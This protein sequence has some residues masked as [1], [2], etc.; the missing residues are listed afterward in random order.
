M[1]LKLADHLDVPLRERNSLLLSAGY[2]PR[3]G[4]M[5]PDDLAVEGVLG[6]LRRMLGAHEPY[7]GVVVDRRWN[8]VAANQAAMW[9]IGTTVVTWGEEPLNVFRVTLHPGGL[10]GY[11]TNLDEWAPHLVGMLRRST[12]LS[13]D[14]ELEALYAEVTTY[15]GLLGGADAGLAR[16]IEV[17]VPI[18]LR[19]PTGALSLYTTLTTLG[20]AT[21]VMVD[22]LAVELFW[23][24]DEASAKLLRAMA[25][26]AGPG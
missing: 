18:R 19:L 1:I 12:A 5:S 13:G 6:S 10:A 16:P 7:P 17:V 21:D 11:S 20:T 9:L 24:S 23:P 8:L 26:G 22:E 25:A 3:F 14:P 15:P 4:R 2:A